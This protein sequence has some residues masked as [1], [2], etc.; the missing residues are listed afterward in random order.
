MRVVGR[1]P[2]LR[3]VG[4]AGGGVEVRAGLVRRGVRGSRSGRVRGRSRQK[5][6]APL[7]VENEEGGLRNDEEG[8]TGNHGGGGRDVA[9][10]DLGGRA[11]TDDDVLGTG[12]ERLLLEAS[13]DSHKECSKEGE[14]GRRE[15][16]TGIDRAELAGGEG[17]ERE[18]DRDAEEE[19]EHDDHEA[20]TSAGGERSSVVARALNALDVKHT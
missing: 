8:S 3:L 6:R 10:S 9:I 4:V 14:D 19:A 5:L 13:P 1:G 20:L 17:E 11:L 7:G 12:D 16:D 2:C 15:L 18:A